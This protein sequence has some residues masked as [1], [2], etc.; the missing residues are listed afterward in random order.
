MSNSIFSKEE[1]EKLCTPFSDYLLK[2]AEEIERRSEEIRLSDSLHELALKATDENIAY[3]AKLATRSKEL[4]ARENQ[5]IEREASSDIGRVQKIAAERKARI[6]VLEENQAQLVRQKNEADVAARQ[7]R[8]DKQSLD[9]AYAALVVEN[10]NL[11]ER[12]DKAEEFAKRFKGIDEGDA[13]SPLHVPPGVVAVDL[14]AKN[15]ALKHEDVLA[16]VEVPF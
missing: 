13:T 14:R 2:C 15:P 1:A 7:A 9:E 11:R 10:G 4:D 16:P 3:A 12:A 8:R 5:L 6:K